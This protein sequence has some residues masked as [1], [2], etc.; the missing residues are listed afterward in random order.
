LAKTGENM[1]NTIYLSP[2]QIP[3][4]LTHGYTGKKFKA[5]ICETATIPSDAGLWSGGSRSTYRMVK[6]SDGAN[7]A[8][9]NHN[10]S[11][12]NGERREI[13]V[14]LPPGVA[15]VEHSIFCGKD[16]GLTFYINPADAP[17]YLPAAV[18]ISD[19][20]RKALGVIC[21]LK[22]AYR[23]EEYARLGMNAADIATAKAELLAAGLITTQ[24]A[25]TPKGRNA[26]G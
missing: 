17:A 6:L 1:Q 23:A 11:P 9:V 5:V 22:S 3:A 16:S 24:G 2:E 26:R 18:S 4:H 10:S 8:P 20:A 19:N 21:G 14:Q 15:L 12:W 13:N 25:V 7:F